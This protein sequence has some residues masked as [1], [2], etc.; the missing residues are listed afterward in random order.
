M[1]NGTAP[2][3]GLTSMLESEIA[4]QIEHGF[5]SKTMLFPQLTVTAAG[6]TSGD[7]TF[8]VTSTVNV[9]PGMINAGGY[10]RREC[11]RKRDSLSHAS[12]SNFVV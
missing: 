4:A 3:F 1:P 11:N 12:I 6:Q 2:L 10:Y 9:L 7:T 5:F 8:T